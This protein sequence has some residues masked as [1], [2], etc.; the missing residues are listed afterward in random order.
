MGK[1]HDLL[2]PSPGPRFET[3]TSHRTTATEAL[4]HRV[5]SDNLGLERADDAGAGVEEI[6]EACR[7]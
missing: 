5:A 1:K 2:Y 7:G 4:E 3:D 6:A